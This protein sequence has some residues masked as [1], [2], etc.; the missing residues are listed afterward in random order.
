MKKYLIFLFI[1]ICAKA[2]SQNYFNK[3]YDYDGTNVPNHAT[4]SL[5]LSN[6]DYLIGG[7]KFFPNYSALYYIRLKANGDTIFCK[8]FPSTINRYYT[9]VGNSLSSTFDGNFIQSGSISSNGSDYNVLLLKVTANGDTLW[10]KTFGGAN[11]EYCNATSQTKDSGYVLFATTQSFSNGS[12]SDFY[13]VKTDKDGNF[14]WQKTYG[15][16]LAED[17]YSGQ[18]TLDDGFIMSG[19]KNNLLYAVKTD[20]NG[21]FQWDRQLPNTAGTGFIK[22]LADSTYLLVGAKII[23]GLGAQACMTKLNKLGGVMWQKTYGDIG[24]QQFYSVPIIL[25]DG[26]IVCAGMSRINNAYGL[27]IKADSAGNQEWLRT[28][29]ANPN[30]DNYVY[31]AKQTSDGGFI[32]T[33]SGNVTSQDAWVV[34]V[35]SVGC[36]IGNCNVGVEELGMEN[37][38]LKVYPNPTNESLT[39]TLSKGEGIGE[40]Q[41]EEVRVYNVLGECVLYQQLIT[42]NQQLTLDVSSLKAGIYFLQVRLLD[43]STGSTQ[44][45]SKKFIKE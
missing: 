42:N 45:K 25:N 2:N 12:A 4:T 26:N 43:V 32:L 38:E 44:V 33:G 22:Q 21:A 17:C 28:Y 8:R 37:G 20:S 35:D 6:G 16:T 40:V 19:I 10:S 18:V 15:S 13:L 23:S 24:D 7:N 34:K 1:L 36:E 39:L 14:E 31:D 9:G 5:E 30:N 41:I 11:Y 29:Y 27:L 3:L